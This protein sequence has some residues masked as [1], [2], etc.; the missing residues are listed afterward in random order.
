[1]AL[2]SPDCGYS[3][4]LNSSDSKKLLVSDTNNEYNN[5]L[6]Y[7]NGLLKC[8]VKAFLYCCDNWR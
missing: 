8:I 1:V 7:F 3:K 2:K 6:C 4:T 5:I